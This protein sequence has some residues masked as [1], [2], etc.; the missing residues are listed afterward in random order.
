MTSGHSFYSMHRFREDVRHVVIFDDLI[1]HGNHRIRLYLTDEAYELT[2]K[3]EA[4]GYIKI[5]YY[6]S[7]IGGNLIPEAKKKHKRH[8]AK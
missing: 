4:K 1:E 5:V 6:A 3:M 8:R 7:V 2:K